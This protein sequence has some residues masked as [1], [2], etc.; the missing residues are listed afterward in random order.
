MIKIVV[1]ELLIFWW[2]SDKD[3]GGGVIEIAVEV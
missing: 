2:R 3:C 1:E